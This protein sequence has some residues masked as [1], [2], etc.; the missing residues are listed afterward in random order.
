MRYLGKNSISS[1]LKAVCN[2]A[3]YIT[4]ML[5]GLLF[6][7]M[8][9]FTIYGPKIIPHIVKDCSFQTHGLEIF[10]DWAVVTVQPLPRSAIVAVFGSALC[11]LAITL[12]VIYQLRK[13]LTHLVQE[14]P[15]V[16]ENVLR[17]RKIGTILV[18][19]AFF[20]SI[21]EYMIGC[22]ITQHIIIQGAKL[23][24]KFELNLQTVVAGLA[25]LVLAEILKQGTE[26]KE[27]QNLTI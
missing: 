1:F 15:F 10:F 24:P 16:K 2:I 14:E 11:F 8:V 7:G 13:I 23:V 22:F 18:G 21:V 25:V 5:G 26:I 20:Q 27:D 4:L 12:F 9:F 19:G 3:W 17:V 6:L